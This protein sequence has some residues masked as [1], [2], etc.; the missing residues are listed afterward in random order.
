TVRWNWG[1]QAGSGKGAPRTP[2]IPRGRAGNSEHPGKNG[3]GSRG[4]ASHSQD[5]GTVSRLQLRI[6][7]IR[8][9]FVGNKG[10]SPPRGR[11]FAAGIGAQSSGRSRP[12]AVGGNLCANRTGETSCPSSAHRFPPRGGHLFAS[13]LRQGVFS[14]GKIQRGGGAISSRLDG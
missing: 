12:C 10:T 5:N 7:G 13:E 14:D 8:P 4:G 6:P 9:F 1:R 2:G 11:L 3:S